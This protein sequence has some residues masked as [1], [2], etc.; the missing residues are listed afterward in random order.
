MWHLLDVRKVCS[1]HPMRH[2]E[3]L[4]LLHNVGAVAK[5]VKLTD[6]SNKP[7]HLLGSFVSN[8]YFS[9][10]LGSIKLDYTY[11]ILRMIHFKHFPNISSTES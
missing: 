6:V 8:K 3:I 10:G 2:N 1:F 7:K 5:W 4:I 11:E 9:R